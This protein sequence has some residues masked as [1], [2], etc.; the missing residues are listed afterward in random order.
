M[1]IVKDLIFQKAEMRGEK[2]SQRKFLKPMLPNSKARELS[3]E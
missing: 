3:N 1:M 2:T